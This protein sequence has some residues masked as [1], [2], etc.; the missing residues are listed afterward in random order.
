V[1][2]QTGLSLLIKLKG[3]KSGQHRAPYFLTGKTPTCRGT[4][5]ATENKLPAATCRYGKRWKGEVRAHRHFRDG[6]C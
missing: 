1:A 2:K 3:G 4:D 5:S 6:V